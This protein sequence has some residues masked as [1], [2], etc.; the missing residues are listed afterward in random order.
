MAHPSLKPPPLKK[1][2]LARIVY[3]IHLGRRTVPE[4]SREIELP[5][6]CVRGFLKD[7]ER[8]FLVYSVRGDGGNEWSLNKNKPD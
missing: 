6:W 1:E 3:S 4:I 8:E 2:I 7:L 5:G